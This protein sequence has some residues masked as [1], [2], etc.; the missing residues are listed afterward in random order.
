[1]HKTPIYNAMFLALT[2]AAITQ[3]A[4]LCTGITVGEDHRRIREQFRGCGGNRRE[5]KP[6]HCRQ[7]HLAGF[8]HHRQCFAIRCRRLPGGS[9]LSLQRQRIQ[10]ISGESPA[11]H[12]RGG[13]SSQS[14]YAL[15]RVRQ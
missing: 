3:A 5:W 8:P 10:T 14:R 2:L 6:V 13:R 4:D 1:M 11:H 15:R 12:F 7:H 9:H